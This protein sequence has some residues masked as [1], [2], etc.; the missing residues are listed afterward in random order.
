[1]GKTKD[2]SAYERG[3][4][5][6]ARR[7]ALSQ[8]R[9]RCW[10]FHAQR[11]PGCIKTGPPPRGHPANLTQLWETLES[12]WAGIPVE[13]FRHLLES[14]SRGQR[15]EG[16]ALQYYEGDPNVWYA[17]CLYLIL[18]VCTVPVISLDTYSMYFIFEIIQS[19]P[20]P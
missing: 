3:M 4:V 2:V 16:D 7:T 20:F 12:T 6:D 1:M 15:G 11:F 8:E 18:L 5:V 17:H 10:V 14:M 13:C 9:H 19:H